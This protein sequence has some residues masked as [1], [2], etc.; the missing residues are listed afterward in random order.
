MHIYLDAN[1]V[2]TQLDKIADE[3]F[4]EFGIDTLDD[5]EAIAQAVIIWL[6]SRVLA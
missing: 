1:R 6:E 3:H 2:K 5:G 4:G